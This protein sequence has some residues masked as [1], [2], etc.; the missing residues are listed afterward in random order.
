MTLDEFM[1]AHDWE[2]LKRVNQWEVERDGDLLHLSLAARDGERFRV[3]V[4]CD[5]YPVT[6]PS[7]VFVNGEGD[8]MNPRAWPKGGGRFYQAVKPPPACFLCVPLT[9]EGLQHHGEWRT[10]PS[11]N[12][13]TG[14]RHSL[15]DVFNLVQ[16]LLFDPDYGGRGP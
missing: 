10:D 8:P 9:R 7:V 6:P 13:W 1:S 16:R 3:R 12:A 15:I 2:L 4:R 11:K 5:G 14:D